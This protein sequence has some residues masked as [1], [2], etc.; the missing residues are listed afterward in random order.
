MRKGERE[1]ARGGEGEGSRM[2]EGR[3]THDG[4]RTKNGRRGEKDH[5]GG[6][7][8]ERRGEEDQDGGGQEGEKVGMWLSHGCSIHLGNYAIT[9]HLSTLTIRSPDCHTTPPTQFLFTAL[10]GNTGT[11]LRQTVSI[12]R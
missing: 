4:R 3:R 7:E 11:R 6:Q 10:N 12:T 2:G 9:T 1:E 5:D 8:E